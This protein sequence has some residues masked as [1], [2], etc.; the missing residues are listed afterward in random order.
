VTQRF[1]SVSLFEFFS[2]ELFSTTR[3]PPEA[4]PTRLSR[5]GTSPLARIFLISDQRFQYL[6]KP[7]R[8]LARR[9]QAGLG[10]T[11]PPPRGRRAA[12]QAQRIARSGL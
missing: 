11:T 3:T 5:N 7:A 6:E 4:L 9:E 1:H 10:V 12:F 2:T 8:H